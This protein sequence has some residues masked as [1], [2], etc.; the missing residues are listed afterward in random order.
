MNKARYFAFLFLS[1]I[2][3]SAC[4]T[5]TKATSEDH[6]ETAK[7]IRDFVGSDTLPTPECHASTL[8]KL[9]NGNFLVAWFGGTHEGHDDVGIYLSEGKPGAWTAPVEV[10]KLREDAHWNPVLFQTKDGN[11]HI[12]FKV[13]KEIGTWETWHSVSGNQ[14]K[15]WS[16]PVELIAGDRGGRGP[17]RSKPIYLSDGSILAGA[18]NEDGPWNVFTDKSTDDGYTWQSS[19]Y[20]ALDR[21]GFK[22]KGVIQPTLWESEEGRVH[23]LVRSTNDRIYRADSE[24]YGVTWGALYDAGLPNPS[25]AIDLARLD[26]Q[27]LILLYNPTTRATGNRSYLHAALSSDNGKTWPKYVVIEA[28]ENAGEGFAYPAVICD[29]D[30]V[31]VTYTVKRRNIKFWQDTKDNIL[32]NALSYATE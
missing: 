2:G 30:H 7:A 1:I 4:N 8:V 23:M 11:I 17:V 27:T 16:E 15:D 22:G 9:A 29:A 13:G 6:Q 24:D 31:Y 21:E 10:F 5:N 28:E 12:Y 26:E 32:A 18:S 14:G 19:G 20:L 25:S 3:L